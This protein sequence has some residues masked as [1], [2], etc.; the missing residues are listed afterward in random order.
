MR[1]EPVVP[2]R[3]SPPRADDLRLGDYVE[4]WSSGPSPLRP[5]RPVL[6]GFPQDAGVRRNRGRPGA[7]AAPLA[8]RRWLFQLAPWDA[9]TGADLAR[10]NLLDLGNIRVGADVEASQADL[11][12]V[13]A[14]VLTA[15]GVPIVL[16]GGHETAYGCYLGYVA[17][18]RPV[19][20]VNIDAH[21]D[22][23]PTLDGSGHS[24][25]PFR[26]ALEHPSQPLQ[27]GRYVCLGAQPHAVSREHL[28]YAR[29]RG[30]VVRWLPEVRGRLTAAFTA[31]RERL[32]AE[33]CSLHVTLDAD[34]VDAAEA[35][36][37]SAPNVCG[38]AGREV[39]ECVQ[40]AGAVPGTAG[41]DLV[42][43]NPSF[44]LDDRSARWGALAIWRFL[45]G[46]ATRSI[47]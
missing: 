4:F 38:L 18:G 30:C 13:V 1:L 24:G 32:A 3:P 47:V 46:L 9:I 27:P 8:I 20:I 22:V 35:P 43:I 11:A 26:Q 16:G 12:S 15:G 42:E 34:A 14:A 25:S 45:V 41:F 31:E 10:S 6:F 17:A 36:G 29:Q 37:V 2:V 21:L 28:H 23:R 5:N 44:D 39:L 7:A 19:A 40:A 33:P